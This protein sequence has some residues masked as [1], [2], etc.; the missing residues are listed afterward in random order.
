MIAADVLD[1]IL[2][3]V[4]KPARY[5]GGEWNQVVK[6]WDACDV[7]WCLVF[8]DIYEIGMS[9]LGLSILYDQL[10][11]RAGP[12][13]LAER[14]YAPWTDMEA[15]MRAAGLPLFSLESRRPLARF[16]IL[17]FSLPYEQLYTNLLNLLDLAGLP[18]L[19][20]ERDERHPLIVAGGGAALNPE[21]MSDFV[22]VFALG[23]GEELVLEI[24][25]AVRRSKRRGE[26]RQGLLRRLAAVP[27]LYVPR[28]YRV[29]YHDDGT[30]A[31]V[32]P[33]RPEAPLPVRKRIVTTLPP[34]VTRPLVPYI[35]TI[36]NRAAIEI[37]RGCTRGCRFCHAGMTYRPVRERPVAEVL[38]AVEEIIAHTGF[39]EIAL[40][41]LSSSDYVGIERLVRELAARHGD[42]HLSIS[43]PSLRIESVSVALMEQ[44]QSTGRRSSFTFAPEAATE[45]LRGV[46]NKPIADEDLLA[47]AEEVYGRG[48]KTI[49]L[50]F[51]IGLPTQTLDDVAAIAD[52]A[53]RVRAV[54]WR[55]LGRKAQVHVSVSTFVPKPH[56]PF[57]WTPLADEE[58][59]KAQ[60]NYLKEHLRGPGL[61]L[62]WNRYR[63]TQ[64]EA[65]L[66]RGDRRLGAVIH[67][68]WQLGARFDGWGDQFKVEAW[69]QAFRESDLEIG[70]YTRRERAL[71]EILPW[72]HIDAGVSKGYLARDYR[73][74]LRG[75]TRPD[76]RQRCYACGI[77]TAFREERAAAPD[78]AWGCP[79]IK[80]L[81]QAQPT[82]GRRPAGE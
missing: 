66:S 16:D 13:T 1:R 45:R 21:P 46:I 51:M 38:A 59:V 81:P 4:S 82:G 17:G 71:D 41:S 60:Q 64:L 58:A 61:K 42:R 24:G 35:N 20:A 70:F 7:R 25:E 8:P 5:T 63:E 80:K 23:D 72:D 78:D 33:T 48:W 57:Q 49:K 10:N 54:G 27:G 47:V 50:Y 30:I 15:A 52:L 3:T 36:H 73:A 55:V 32:E 43:L 62:N 37:Q 34:P 14:A 18:V 40:L 44:L 22:D 76:C 79:P 69:R 68:A 2:P 74:S 53:H 39:E 26:S 9:N 11:R 29:T 28:F 65:V 67:R 31:G 77:L 56:T 6:D 75:E 19:A 12:G